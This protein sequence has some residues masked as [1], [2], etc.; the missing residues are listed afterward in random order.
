MEKLYVTIST[1]LSAKVRER[2]THH[3]KLRMK[4][5]E[6]KERLE[7]L[8]RQEAERRQQEEKIAEEF[9]LKQTE[10]VESFIRAK[11]TRKRKVS[12]KATGEPSASDNESVDAQE[13]LA[14]DAKDQKEDSMESA[15][16]KPVSLKLLPLQSY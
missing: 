16:K 5:R 10:L 12:T 4:E 1:S 3:E 7:E 9:R 8:R 6:D 15:P 13:N 14:E 2:E 11:T